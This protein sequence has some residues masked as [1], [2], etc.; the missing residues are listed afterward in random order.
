MH[1]NATCL[2]N[3]S[4]INSLWVGRITIFLIAKQ[5]VLIKTPHWVQTHQNKIQIIL[6]VC[7]L[8]T[9]IWFMLISHCDNLAQKYYH[10]QGL[11]CTRDK[12]FMALLVRWSSFW[13]GQK[14]VLRDLKSELIFNF[15]AICTSSYWIFRIYWIISTYV[16]NQRRTGLHKWWKL[17][18]TI[19]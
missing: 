6:L 19:S 4:N 18:S 10:C 7:W 9:E 13:M 15:C 2:Y 11:G 12:Q 14:S 16:L 8:L 1:L 17:I 3:L 5:M